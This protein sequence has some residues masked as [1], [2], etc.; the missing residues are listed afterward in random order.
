MLAVEEGTAAQQFDTR[1][2]LAQLLL[3]GCQLG[4]QLA[5]ARHVESGEVEFGPHHIP[6]AAIRPGAAE[7]TLF[8]QL[9][10]T[11]LL[12]HRSAGQQQ[13]IGL[14]LG[15]RDAAKGGVDLPQH[16]L[17]PPLGATGQPRPRARREVLPRHLPHVALPG[18][19]EGWLGRFK[20]FQ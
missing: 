2:V 12:Q 18:T 17:A 9:H 1:I 15:A 4:E 6:A 8:V 19:G 20:M 7:P 13:G 3:G 5:V 14:P 10:R 11:L 16:P